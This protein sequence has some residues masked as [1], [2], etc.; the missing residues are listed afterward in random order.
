MINPEALNWKYGDSVNFTIVDGVL[1]E[2]SGADIPTIDE[3]EV[4]N[5]EYEH[6]LLVLDINNTAYNKIIN[7]APEYMQMNMTARSAELLEK[8]IEGGTLS[9]EEE[10]EREYI[11]SI[12]DRVK[13]LR[14]HAKYLKSEVEAGNNPDINTGW[15]E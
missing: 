8:I 7:I 13:A 11:R 10:A 2:F 9:E 12:W 3:I 4:I 15:S 5:N 1:K 6:Y 14:A